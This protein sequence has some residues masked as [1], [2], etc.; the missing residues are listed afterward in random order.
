ML[1]KEL[2]VG[3]Y[4]NST[5]KASLR[6]P[7]SVDGALCFGGIDGLRKTVH[8]ASYAIR[9]TPRRPGSIWSSVNILRALGLTRQARMTPAGLKAF[10]DRAPAKSGRYSFENRL[11]HLPPRYLKR[12]K[13]N[14]EAWAFF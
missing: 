11:R 5:G 7:E 4:N 6:W 3:F 1:S 8:D 10:N 14:E 12:L 13:A 9:F 2:R